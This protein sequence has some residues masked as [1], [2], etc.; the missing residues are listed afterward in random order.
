MTHASP[1]NR[2]TATRVPVDLGAT[3][4][5]GGAPRALRVTDLSVDG[6]FLEGEQAAPGSLLRLVL[7]LRHGDEPLRARAVVVRCSERGAGVRFDG[8][9]TRDRVR[10]ADRLFGGE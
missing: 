3:A 6:A 4:R 7:A 8:L 2:R 1:E 10:I 5:D 9:P